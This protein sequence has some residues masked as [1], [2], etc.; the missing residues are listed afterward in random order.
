VFRFGVFQFVLGAA[1][2]EF[3]CEHSRGHRVDFYSDFV[4]V[5]G[6]RIVGIKYT[7]QELFADTPSE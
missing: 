6:V 3:V 4:D 7:V 1:C 2:G 5:K